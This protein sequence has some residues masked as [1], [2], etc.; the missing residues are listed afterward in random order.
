LVSEDWLPIKARTTDG[1]AS[2]GI[3]V[4]VKVFEVYEDRMQLRTELFKGAKVLVFRQPN[5]SFGRKQ[6]KNDAPAFHSRKWRTTGRM[7]WYS[8]REELFRG[9]PQTKDDFCLMFKESGNRLSF[10]VSPVS[11]QCGAGFVPG[12]ARTGSGNG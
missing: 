5:L 1:R 12:F 2:G 9:E 7:R 3:Q 6:A 8:R 10:C 11:K 4:V